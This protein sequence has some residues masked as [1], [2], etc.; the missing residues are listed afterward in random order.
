M[1][2]GIPWSVKGIND[3]ARE[4]AKHAARRS[5]MTL[6]EWLNTVIREQA[7]E[8]EPKKTPPARDGMDIQSKLDH[9]SE[10]LTRRARRDQDTAAARHYEHSRPASEQSLAD[11]LARV[12]ASERQ[13]AATYAQFDQRL[14]MLSDKFANGVQ[15]FSRNPDDVPGYRSLETAVRKIV[16]HI[17]VSE[18]KT[19]DTLNTMQ[20][21]LNDIP[22]AASAS[23]ES[24][25]VLANAPLIAR[26]ENRMADLASRMSEEDAGIRED[27]R[28]LFHSEFDKLAARI[29]QVRQV[30]EASAHRAETQAVQQAQRDLREF[31]SRMEDFLTAVQAPQ[32][33]GRLRVEMEGLDQRVDDLKSEVASEHDLRS[34]RVV[35][36]QLSV[37]IAQGPDLR[38]LADL[39]RRLTEIARL[40]EQGRGDRVGDQI[41]DLEQR[42]LE[43]DN[44]IAQ[45][46][47]HDHAVQALAGIEREFAGLN[48][49]LAATEQQ[50]QHIATLEQSIHQLYQSM[51]QSREGARETAEYATNRMAN[52]LMEDWQGK[53]PASGSS[54]EVRA[55]ENALEMVKANYETADRRNQETLRGVHE[56]LAQIINKMTELEQLRGERQTAAE[57]E[58]SLPSGPK[59]PPSVESPRNG[60]DLASEA[61]LNPYPPLDP[62]SLRPD[63]PIPAVQDDFIAAARRAAQA[64]ARPAPGATASSL[65]GRHKSAQSNAAPSRF[66][67]R[68]RKREKMPA[69]EARFAP[70]AATKAGSGKR[71]Q[72]IL[73]GILLLVAV[74]AFAYNNYVRKPAEAPTIAP[75]VEQM[76]PS[77]SSSMLEDAGKSVASPLGTV[78]AKSD[79]FL[80]NADFA[81]PAQGGVKSN[82]GEIAI[83]DAEAIPSRIGS[84]SLRQAALDGDPVV[85]FLVNP[86]VRTAIGHADHR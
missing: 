22:D 10:Q 40:L 56:T 81:S 18:R 19:R 77:G 7:D 2:P 59:I 17:E 58:A 23:L 1:K 80:G 21:R 38:P 51:E 50:L 69:E 55:L 26:I 49:R 28:K 11:I 65:L 70:V 20:E 83:N 39:D 62:P 16:D 3:E 54:P 41:A 86:L 71:Q 24:D 29:D 61:G 9:L 85:A 33:L 66:F 36:E 13:A 57:V 82:R 46:M 63:E 72:M 74:S 78:L 79:A 53:A 64:A 52:R 68:I 44:R 42:V 45:A 48:G 6:G 4:A 73:I 34:L 47:R 25:R 76:N 60:P 43:L 84:E 32:E 75:S 12:E 37:R 8:A 35:I 15:S 27:L 67:L 14:E 31:E 30:A 5:G